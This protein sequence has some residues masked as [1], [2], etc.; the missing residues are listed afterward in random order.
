M[1]Y[2]QNWNV[3]HNETKRV[4]PKINGASVTVNISKTE[5]VDESLLSRD[6]EAILFDRFRSGDS[7]ARFEI[8]NANLRLV[9]YVVKNYNNGHLTPE[10]LYQEGVFGLMAAID[11]FDPS[12][13]TKFSTYA[14]W[15]I[16]QYVSRAVIEQ[17]RIIRIPGNIKDDLSK[18]NKAIAIL[19]SSLGYEPTIEEI[20]EILEI[21]VEKVSNLFNWAK[22]SVSVDAHNFNEDA[23]EVTFEDV[24]GNLNEQMSENDRND[25][26]RLIMK[27]LRPREEQV[28]R[29]RYG[30]GE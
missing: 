13:G 11:K 16:R 14:Y 2:N 21:S 1:A 23:E 17:G 10:D 25:Q 29:L 5:A 20:A 18:L 22:D 3:M 12:K 28:L 8:A 30:F 9:H 27:T 6:E 7:K 26:I 24:A 4:R 19:S 15:W